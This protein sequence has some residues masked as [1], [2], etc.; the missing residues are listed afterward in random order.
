MCGGGPPKPKPPK[1]APPMQPPPIVEA[2]PEVAVGNQSQAE[3]KRRKVG[4]SS[5][6]QAPA[7]SGGSS[8]ASSGLGS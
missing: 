1:P 7:S 3:S 2:A 8:K 4:R 6:R 5:L